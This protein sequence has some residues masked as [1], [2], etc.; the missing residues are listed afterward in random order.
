MKD[1]T[2]S[3]YM[4]AKRI[5]KDFEFKNVGEYHDLHLN[6]DTLI[7]VDVLKNFGKNL[8]KVYPLHPPLHP[9]FLSVPGLT[10]PVALKKAE[11]KLE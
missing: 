2:N 9:S 4:H 1:V 3:D 11:V 10:W 7:S 6:I 8:S 5:S